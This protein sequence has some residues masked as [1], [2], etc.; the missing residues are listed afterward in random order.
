MRMK[1]LLGVSRSAMRVTVMAMVKGAS[2][3]VSQKRRARVKPRL[4]TAMADTKKMSS[5]T[6]RGTRFSKLARR[7]S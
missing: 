3:T 7:F 2:R 1:P 4:K 5:Q 6:E